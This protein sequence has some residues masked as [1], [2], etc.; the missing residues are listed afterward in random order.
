MHSMRAVQRAQRRCPQQCRSVLR[1]VQ[2]QCHPS[3]RQDSHPKRM[4]ERGPEAASEGRPPARTPARSS[5]SSNLQI[6]CRQCACHRGSQGGLRLRRLEKSLQR[7]P[8]SLGPLTV[9]LRGRTQ[10]PDQSRGRTISSRARG[11]TTVHHGPLQR[12][13]GIGPDQAKS[14]DLLWHRHERR[15]SCKHWVP[16][17]LRENTHNGTVNGC[18]NDALNHAGLYKGQKCEQT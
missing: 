11:D 4:K 2:A 14:R 5:A 16:N 18:D 6:A 10:A 8:H 7:P 12:L 9:K 17:R 15:V 1:Y 3:H 13:L